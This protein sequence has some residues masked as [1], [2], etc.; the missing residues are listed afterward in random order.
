MVANTIFWR[1]SWE[2]PLTV[3]SVPLNLQFSFC[4]TD[5]V[6]LSLSCNIDYTLSQMVDPLLRAA[7][8][9]FI[10]F[11]DKHQCGLYHSPSFCIISATT[12]QFSQDS[13]VIPSDRLLTLFNISC[14][15]SIVIIF[16]SQVTINSC[17]LFTVQ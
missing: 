15:A 17:I 4:L 16:L 9:P 2:L 13:C 7:M 5:D 6:L 8:Y 14:N 1:G 3:T 12:F 10:L 11:T